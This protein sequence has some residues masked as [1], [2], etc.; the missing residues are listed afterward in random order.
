MN[1][2]LIERASKFPR[3]KYGPH[4]RPKMLAD[5]A[6][7]EIARREAEIADDLQNMR[8]STTGLNRVSALGNDLQA[9]IN[10]LRTK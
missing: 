1:N 2:E 9:Y 4:Q 5:F 6:A 3:E 8:N 10:K 7:A